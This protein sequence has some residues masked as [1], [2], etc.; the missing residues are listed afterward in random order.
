M[1]VVEDTTLGIQEVRTFPKFCTNTLAVI[2][3]NLTSLHTFLLVRRL[4]GTAWQI[5]RVAM[6]K[7]VRIICRYGETAACLVS[8]DKYT[9]EKVVIGLG[10]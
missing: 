1:Y 9:G 2:F 4:G 3:I 5:W 7:H 10:R 6:V 8:A